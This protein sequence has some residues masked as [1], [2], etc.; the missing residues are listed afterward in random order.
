MAAQEA[1]AAFHQA[2]CHHLTWESSQGSAAAVYEMECQSTL[3]RRRI[4]DLQVLVD[5][6]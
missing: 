5:S 6:P 3:H 4:A 2:E 1:W